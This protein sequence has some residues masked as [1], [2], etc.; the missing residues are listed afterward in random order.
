[1][2]VSV[3]MFVRVCVFAQQVTVSSQDMGQKRHSIDQLTFSLSAC[4]SALEC[5]PGVCAHH[6]CIFSTM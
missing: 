5:E 4:A 6:V 1:M 2:C 3:C